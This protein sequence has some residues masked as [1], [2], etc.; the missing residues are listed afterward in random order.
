MSSAG[1]PLRVIQKISRHRSLQAL[2]RYLDVSEGQ[3]EGAL[4]SP[5][6]VLS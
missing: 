2:Q 1:V 5:A 6:Q 4:G 3:L